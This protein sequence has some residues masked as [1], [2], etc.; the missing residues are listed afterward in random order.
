[1]NQR[2]FPLT[3]LSEFFSTSAPWIT[4]WC[5]QL[6]RAFDQMEMFSYSVV[7]LKVNAFNLNEVIWLSPN[8]HNEFYK[9]SNRR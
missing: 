5:A 2:N 7:E 9:K 8:R 3:P 6:Q 4:C 1:M